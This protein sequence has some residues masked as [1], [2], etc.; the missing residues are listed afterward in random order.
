MDI[1]KS[2]QIALIHQG[3]KK[4]DLADQLEVSR[5]YVSFLVGSETCSP[6]MLNRLSRVFGMKASEFIALGE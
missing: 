1:G 3:I 5:T 4:K 6:T 2:I